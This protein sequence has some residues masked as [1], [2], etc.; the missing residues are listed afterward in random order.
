MELVGSVSTQKT[1]LH[2]KMEDYVMSF[3]YYFKVHNS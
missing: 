1:I 3:Q 2:K